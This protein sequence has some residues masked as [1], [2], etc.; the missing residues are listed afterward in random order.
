[1]A[2]VIARLGRPALPCSR[3]TRRSA[4]RS[5]PSSASLC[6]RERG[7]YFRVVLRLLPAR[8]PT[9]PRAILYIEKARR[10]TNHIEQI[11]LSATK[12][13]SAA[14]RRSSSA[15]S[16]RSTASATLPSI[17]GMILH[18]RQARTLSPSATCWRGSS[19]CST[20]ATSS[21]SA[22]HVSACRDV[23]D[24]LPGGGTRSTRIRVSLIQIRS[25]SSR[26]RPD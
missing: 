7:E 15:P 8:G 16:R 22:R 18:L 6:A 26:S 4:H 13:L 23:I 5:T 2:H 3:R 25:R 24:V 14:R 9:S 20:S 1:M 12:S 19:P 21:T 11:A 17:S 10:S